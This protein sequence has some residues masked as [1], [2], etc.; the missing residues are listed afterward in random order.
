VVSNTSDIIRSLNADVPPKPQVDGIIGAGT[1]AGTRLRLD[2]P[3]ETGGRVV[4]R[5]EAGSAR[6]LC[7]AAPSCP[8]LSAGDQTHTCFGHAAAGLAARPATDS[9]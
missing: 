3:A 8:P 4:V 2:Y 7:W 6:E 1:L 5:C 9:R